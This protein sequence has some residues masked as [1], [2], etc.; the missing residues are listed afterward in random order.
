MIVG[1]TDGAD[2][3]KHKHGIGAVNLPAPTAAT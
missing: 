1:E 2:L 3:S